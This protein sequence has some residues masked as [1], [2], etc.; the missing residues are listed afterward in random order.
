MSGLPQQLVDPFRQASLGAEYCGDLPFHKMPRLQA[1]LTEDCEG[2]VSYR[3]RFSQPRSRQFRLEGEVGAVV[4]L[5]CQ[6]CFRPSTHEIG[7]EFRFALLETEDEIDSLTETWE[8]LVLGEARINLTELLEDELLLGLP[9]VA[10]H[11]NPDD[12]E[13]SDWQRWTDREATKILMVD[14]VKEENPFAA[15]AAL[16]KQPDEG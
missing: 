15:L 7:G 3:L 12:C 5:P 8:P 13:D 9:G 10:L 1:L 2:S 4:S 11:E 16:K 14:D 6:R